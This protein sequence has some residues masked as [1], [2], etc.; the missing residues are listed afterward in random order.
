MEDD[1]DESIEDNLDDITQYEQVEQAVD[2]LGMG[3][4]GMQFYM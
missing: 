3:M 1:D 2:Q 4:G